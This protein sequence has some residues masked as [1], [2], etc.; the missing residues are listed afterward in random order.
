MTIKFVVL[1][2]T[3]LL[4]CSFQFL[5]IHVHLQ[6]MDFVLFFFEDQQSQVHTSSNDEASEYITNCFDISVIKFQNKQE[7]CNFVSRCLVH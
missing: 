6:A 4:F 7:S 3:V 1:I 2:V 5:V